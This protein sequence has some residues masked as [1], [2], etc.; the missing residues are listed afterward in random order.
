MVV[1][2]HRTAMIS[3]PEKVTFRFR[4]PA[5]IVVTERQPIYFSTERDRNMGTFSID[6][7]W[8]GPSTRH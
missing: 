1:I 7:Q 8:L 6:R 2:C 5:G 3:S 4:N